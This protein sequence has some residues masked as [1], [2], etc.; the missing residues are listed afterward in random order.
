MVAKTAFL[1]RFFEIF[2]SFRFFGGCF[3]CLWLFGLSFFCWF[4][5]FWRFWSWGFGC[6]SCGWGLGGCSCLSGGLFLGFGFLGFGEFVYFL[7]FDNFFGNQ[8]VMNTV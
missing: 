6:R 7:A 3:L 1:G 4:F 2:L 8:E 5:L